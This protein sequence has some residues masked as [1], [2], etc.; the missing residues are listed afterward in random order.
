M[1]KSR[2]LL[3]IVLIG[4]VIYYLIPFLGR[5]M[6]NTN[7][8]DYGSLCVYFIN[9]IYA[10]VSGIILT[11]NNGFKWYY[12]FIIGILFIPASLYFFNKETMIYSMLYILEYLVGGS[13]YIKYKN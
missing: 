2:N 6:N 11:K 4:I 12:S 3:I 8:S 13:L 10:I 9:S 1:K 7:S 5:G